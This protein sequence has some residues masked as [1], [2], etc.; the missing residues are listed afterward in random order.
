MDAG[1]TLDIPGT[2]QA[3][4]HHTVVIVGGGAA[5]I[6]VAASLMRRRPSL[7][8]ALI[9]P[10]ATH[11]YQPAFT[12]VGGGAYA[13]KDTERRQED[14][15]PR[16]VTWIKQAA[17]GFL[18]ETN[19][20]RLADG[21]LVGYDVLVACPGLQ[22]DWGKVA[23]LQETLGKNGVCSNYLAPSAE[24]TWE[25]VKS[26]RGGTALF[27]QPAMPIKCAGAPQKVMY[28]AAD[29]FRRTGVAGKTKVEFLLA[30]DVLFGVP[31]FVPPLQRAIA[32]YG[33]EVGFKHNLMAID[34]PAKTAIFSAT[35]ADGTATE[36]SK[37]FNMIHVTP[38]Q[39]AP[40]FV[41]ASPLANAA[42]WIDVDPASLRHTRFA[43]VFALGDATATANAK[44]AAAVRMQAPVVVRNL[45]ATLDKN[46]PEAAYDGYGSCP[47]IVGR[48]KVVLAEFAY[49]GKVVPSFPLDPRVPR[50]SMWHLKT[51]LLPWLYWNVMLKGKELDIGHRERRF[52]S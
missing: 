14:L 28:L 43:N 50:A 5:G 17:A 10:A 6:S 37:R 34:G 40:D 35:A 4:G 29:H 48:G 45:L 32:Q 16:G 42:G 52:P 26:F 3:G 18:P 23:G 31:F 7:R 13:R 19:Q 22:F 49:G 21:G 36:I 15:I 2:M 1:A 25:C 46:Q 24:Y 38:P 20:V 33:I 41:K 27:T 9:D 47:L 44:T 12:L 39:S 8:V 30:G 11:W 51:K